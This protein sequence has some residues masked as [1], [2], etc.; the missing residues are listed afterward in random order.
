MNRILVPE[1]INRGGAAVRDRTGQS[2][3]RSV[4]A[5]ALE[6][7]GHTHGPE[8][9]AKALWPRD[10]AAAL[11]TRSAV[12]PADTVTSGW[13]SQ[14][15]QTVIPDFISSLAPVSAGAQLLSRGLQFSF[16]NNAGILVPGALADAS[17]ASFVAQAAPIPTE[18]L[19]LTGPT[20][21]PKKLA[22][23]SV[24]SRETFEH[25]LPNIEAFVGDVLRASAAHSLDIIM[26]DS[27]AGDTVRPAGLRQGI[28]ATTA[29]ADTPDE[30]A[31]VSD[32]S[33][34]IGSVSAAA[35]S[36]EIVIV[37]SPR[38]AAAIKV[39]QP[40]FPFAIFPSSGLSA[41]TVVAIAMNA[42]VS[43]VAP[44]PRIEVSSRGTIHAE[45]AIPLSISS[46]TGSPFTAPV[47]SLWQT[48]TLSI[49]FV[50]E[51]SWALRNAAG[52]AWTQTVLW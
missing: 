36:S 9:R 49:K 33:V 20:L 51:I 27:T 4:I 37:A 35:G 5:F 48:D 25:S 21:T 7:I 6:E 34:L 52:L 32:L 28:S 46:T 31:M 11:V 8:A 43:A 14:L 50:L 42:L 23:L 44:V 22:A 38:Q 19:A 10:E 18:Q 47:R 2:L 17:E 24:Y 29:S 45:D 39:R 30:A 13:A 26:L 41:G 15:A 16:D 3:V 40:N 12:V 1:D